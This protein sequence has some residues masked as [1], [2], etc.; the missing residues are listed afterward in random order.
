MKLEKLSKFLII[1]LIFLIMFFYPPFIGLAT[2]EDQEI[3]QEM[4][5]GLS[6]LNKEGARNAVLNYM[7]IGKDAILLGYWDIAASCFEKALQ[8]IETVY[9]NTQMAAEARSMW[10]EEG[11]KTFKGEPYERAMAY[12]Y[13]GLTYIHSGEFDNARACFESGLLQDAFAEEEQNQTDFALLLLMSGWCALQMENEEKANESFKQVQMLRSDAKIPD[14]NH[15]VMILVET[16]TAPRKLS[17][18]IGHAELVFRRGKIWLD[19]ETNKKAKFEDTHARISLDDNTAENTFPLENIYYQAA[20]RGGRPIDRILE[21]QVKFKSSASNLGGVFLDMGCSTWNGKEAGV[22]VGIGGAVTLF[23][24]KAKPHADIRYWKNLPD[25]VHYHP[26]HLNPGIH[27]IKVDFLDKS[28]NVLPD[29][30]QTITIEVLEN[31]DPQVV[32][33][34]CHPQ[35]FCHGCLPANDLKR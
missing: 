28:D 13:R 1:T 9:A 21:G 16:G 33:V 3:P 15:N 23:A 2:E 12:F 10:H 26:I 27:T 32:L 14:G 7:Q 18:G 8:G 29:L 6:T 4:I 24:L 17:D 20:T 5:P 19:L 31:G 34:A 22:L 30:T 11:A 35:I 25:A